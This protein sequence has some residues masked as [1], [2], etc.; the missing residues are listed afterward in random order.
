MAQ[1]VPFGHEPKMPYVDCDCEITVG[2]INHLPGPINEKR[3]QEYKDKAIETILSTRSSTLRNAEIVISLKD[4]Q[5]EYVLYAGG[6]A[7]KFA[8]FYQNSE[9]VSYQREKSWWLTLRETAS[10]VFSW[11]KDN[12]VPIGGPL[13]FFFAKKAIGYK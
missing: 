4:D 10:S 7:N 3:N 5:E 2:D 12:A 1:S 8:I 6:R 13:M 9:V 11:F